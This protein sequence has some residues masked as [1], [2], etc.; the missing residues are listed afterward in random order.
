MTAAQ[1]CYKRAMSIHLQRQETIA[2][3]P[4][5]HLEASTSTSSSSSEDYNYDRELG[6][7]AVRVLF[8]HPGGGDIAFGPCVEVDLN[9]KSIMQMTH[10]PEPF[11]HVPIPEEHRRVMI[12]RAQRRLEL[13]QNNATEDEK[14]PAYLH[15][16][17]TEFLSTES[18]E[19]YD[20]RKRCLLSVLWDIN[21]GSLLHHVCTSRE[22]ANQRM[23]TLR[24]GSFL[25]RPSS[26]G[27]SKDGTIRLRAIT[28]KSFDGRVLEHALVAAVGGLG[29]LVLCLN[30]QE[31]SE[32]YRHGGMP[33]PYHTYHEGKDDVRYFRYGGMFADFL[34]VLVALSK[35]MGFSLSQMIMD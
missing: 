2:L 3:Q 9:L 18:L 25:I 22:E 6:S 34:D 19:T 33:D 17:F 12:Q 29:Y 28:C 16:I 8:T 31:V 5:L 1:S 32:C 15:A 14:K 26:I 30:A 27:D 13:V 23:T 11:E 4:G 21:E 24:P 20:A 7:F 10:Y 35:R